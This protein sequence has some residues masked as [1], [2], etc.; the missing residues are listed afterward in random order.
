[1]GRPVGLHLLDRELVEQRAHHRARHAVAAVEH[2]LHRAHRRGVDEPHRRRLEVGGDVL[3]A[4]GSALRRRAVE[5]AA[6]HHVADLADAGVARQR[7]RPALDHLRARVG[8]G[9]VR[10][11]AHQ[12]A[13]EVARADREIEHL[14]AHLADVEHGGALVADAL[15]VAGRHLG[16]GEPHVAADRQLELGGRGA[17]H[18]RD[19]ARERSAHA[20]GHVLVQL[21]AVEA[22]YVVGLE[23][24]GVDRRHCLNLT[25]SAFQ[26]SDRTW[27]STRVLPTTGMKFVSAAQRG[28]TCRWAWSSTP[29]PA[30]LPWLIPMLKPSGP[31]SSRS[32]PIERLASSIISVSTGS[33][34]SSI[35]GA[36]AYGATITWPLLYG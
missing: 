6:A 26:E 34:S 8:L 17:L 13:S 30:I 11:G 27:G 4:H 5:L 22:A 14:G 2:D 7:D 15:D 36:C 32:T 19:H 20:V 12:P 18:V 33:P 10:G 25:L 28:T 3:L 21:V 31:Y 24:A 1:V 29:A 23:D 16:R 9:V 35:D